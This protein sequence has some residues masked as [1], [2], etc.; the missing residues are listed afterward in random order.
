MNLNPMAAQEQRADVLEGAHLSKR[1]VVESGLFEKKKWLDALSDVSIAVRSGETLG[2]VGE[3]GCGKS[4]LGRVLLRLYKPDQGTVHFQGKDITQASHNELLPF[5]RQVQMVFQDPYGSLNPRM[6]IQTALREVLKVHKIENSKS[7]QDD[8]IAQ[9]LTRVGLKPEHMKR[10][11]REFSGGQRQRIGIAR[12]LTVSPSIIVADE[13]VSA[14]DVSVQAQVINLFVEL[15]QE[16]ALGYLFISHDLRVVRHMSHRVAV[17]YLGRIVETGPSET[18][19]HRPAHPYTCALLAALPDKAEKKSLT[20]AGDPP[21]PIHA[22]TGC[23]F[24]TRC[25]LMKPG[26]CDHERP[27]LRE[28][29]GRAVACHFAEESLS[30]L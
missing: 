12:A 10:L 2:V 6:R 21:N 16:R 14:L 3:S 18:L 29:E 17:M 30:R 4:T 24:H 25:P 23:A 1:F 11:P 13:P 5:R 8:R 9:L 20:L 28:V 7:A 26:T 27:L 22:P 19:Y 15:Q